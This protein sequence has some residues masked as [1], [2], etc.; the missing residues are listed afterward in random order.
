MECCYL[1]EEFLSK[2]RL[3]IQFLDDLEPCDLKDITSELIHE[4][5][6]EARPH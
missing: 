6:R 1:L 5:A 4:L 2:T 3:S